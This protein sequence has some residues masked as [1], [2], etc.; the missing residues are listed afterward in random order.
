MF[1]KI[2]IVAS[3]SPIIWRAIQSYLPAAETTVNQS[4]KWISANYDNLIKSYKKIDLLIIDDNLPS[5]NL[6]TTLYHVKVIVNLTSRQIRENEIALKLP[7][8]L[9]QLL[10]IIDTIRFQQHIFTN[11]NNGWIYDEQQAYLLN[12]KIRIRLTEKENKIFKHL[13]LAPNNQIDKDKLLKN[14]WQYHPDTNSNT[15]E[16]HLYRLKQKLP[17]QMIISQENYYQLLIN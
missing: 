4:T 17:P 10:K 11:I 7:I 9:S 6:A 3:H 8:K 2:E 5:H 1:K 12:K 14:V 16:T 13:L 15:I